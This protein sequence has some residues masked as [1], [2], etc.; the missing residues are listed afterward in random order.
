MTDR[1][2]FILPVELIEQVTEQGL[3]VVPELIGI[4]INAAMQAERSEYLQA[5]SYQHGESAEA[6]P[7][8]SSARRCGRGPA[9]SSLRY[10]SPGRRSERALALAEMSV[11]GVSTRKAKSITLQ[12]CGFKI[13]SSVIS[14]AAM[15]RKSFDC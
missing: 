12:M 4:V 13:A 10:R 2:D 7:T 3:S 8:D 15:S 14:H 5:A 11:Q 9:R 6:M 1:Q